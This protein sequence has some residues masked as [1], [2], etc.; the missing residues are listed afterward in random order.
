MF[1][2]INLY[3]LLLFLRW[4]SSLALLLDQYEKSADAQK[5]KSNSVSL[6]CSLLYLHSFY[7]YLLD[8]LD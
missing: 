4:L 1:N 5:R 7:C 3:S 2:I 8:V 6:F